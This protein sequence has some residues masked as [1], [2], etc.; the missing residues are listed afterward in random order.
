MHFNVSE[1]VALCDLCAR[2]NLLDDWPIIH[3]YL[4]TY[5]TIYSATAV[6]KKK[7]KV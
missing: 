1:T 4:E 7:A 5:N 3:I 6:I 2:N